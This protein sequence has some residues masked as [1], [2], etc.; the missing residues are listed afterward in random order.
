MANTPV[1]KK[2]SDVVAQDAN[3]IDMSMFAADAGL[4]NKEV[5]QES[6][7][8]PFLKT[9]LT[10]QIRALHKWCKTNNSITFY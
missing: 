1:Q 9:N 3:V 8:I 10:K 7:S 5:D 6:L 2:Q 4:G